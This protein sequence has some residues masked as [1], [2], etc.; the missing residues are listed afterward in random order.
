MNV[1][2][3]ILRKIINN[4]LDK[5]SINRGNV[6]LN[7]VSGALH[8]AWGHIFNN[9]LH[10]FY[11]EFGVYTGNSATKALINFNQLKLWSNQQKISSEFWRREIALSSPLNET[12]NFHFLDTFE[13]MPANNSNNPIFAEGTYKSNLDKVKHFIEKYSFQDSKCFFY[14]GLFVDSRDDLKINIGSEKVAIVN[15]DCDLE[16][17]T[18]DA[19]NI[20]DSHF[21]IG[22]I[23]LFDDYNCFNA[24]NNFGQRKAFKD[25]CKKSY[26]I[27][28]MFFNYGVAGQSFLIVDENN[29]T[30]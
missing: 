5:L 29:G 23:L 27:F 9:N 19:L 13:G 15:F 12:I 21:Q 11:I 25:Y 4:I 2:K 24:N 8:K 17:S 30:I 1:I 18:T 22:S 20:V 28:E 14:K 10:G 6:N 7:D 26:F 3:N 16:S